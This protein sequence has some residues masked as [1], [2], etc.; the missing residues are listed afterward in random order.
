MSNLPQQFQDRVRDR[1][2]EVIGDLIPDDAWK[3]MVDKTISDFIRDD[4]PK[5]VKAEMTA[6]M[7]TA[8]RKELDGSEWLTQ[9]SGGNHLASPMMAEVLK[10]T[11]PEMVAALFGSIAQNAMLMVRNNM[12]GY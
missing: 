10:Q 12:K 3:S 1:M 5:L 7:Q 2:K 4:L 9:W 6:Q 11:A 8:I